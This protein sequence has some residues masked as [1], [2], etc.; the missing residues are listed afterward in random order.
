MSVIGC[1]FLV[2]VSALVATDAARAR[3]VT[4][5]YGNVVLELLRARSFDELDRHLA[6]LAK[7]KPRTPSGR[8]VLEVAY[9]DAANG[10]TAEDLESLR[11][12]AERRPTSPRALTLLGMALIDQAW[13]ARG[14]GTVETVSPE[15]WTLFHARIAAA[16][17]ALE[18]A[19]VLTKDDPNAAA[20]LITVCKAESAPHAEHQRWLARA[21]ELDPGD[22]TAANNFREA[23]S[24][25]WGGSDEAMLDFARQM[26]KAAPPGTQFPY[27]VMAAH[28]ELDGSLDDPDY[29]SRPEVKAEADEA[30]GRLLADFPESLAMRDL[31][32]YTALR[33]GDAAAAKPHLDYLDGR[34]VPGR[35]LSEGYYASMRRRVSEALMTPA[36]RRSGPRGLRKALRPGELLPT[37]VAVVDPGAEPREPLRFRFTPG[38]RSVLRLDLSGEQLQR[39]EQPRAPVRSLTRAL[40]PESI[41]LAAAVRTVDARGDAVLDLTIL[42]AGHGE[43]LVRPHVETPAEALATL[44]GATGHVT[45]TSRGELRESA[46]GAPAGSPPDVRWEWQRVSAPWPSWCLPFPEEPVGAGARWTATGSWWDEGDVMHQEVTCKVVERTE[47]TVTLALDG[48][49]DSG[50]KRIRIDGVPP[51]VP[52]ELAEHVVA[53]WTD[54]TFDL[55]RPLPESSRGGRSSYRHVCVGDAHAA[56]NTKLI[57]S[58]TL[59]LDWS[60]TDTPTEPTRPRWDASRPAPEVEERAPAA[61]ARPTVQRGS[62]RERSLAL[63]GGG[64][65]AALLLALLL[66]RRHR[67]RAAA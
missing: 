17:E 9:S 15:G 61:P 48:I 37:S 40:R 54:V 7:D 32:A 67:A 11:E 12:W 10:L 59:S 4:Q 19:A 1:R 51:D 60:G 66:V 35:W 62:G 52:V 28:L 8:R 45:M 46:F 24:A 3:P 22:V 64:G 21:L 26:A 65:V 33:R 34:Y 14:S 57:A 25:K 13:A 43:K 23:L 20:A 47:G 31:A 58:H 5:S 39:L 41:T 55:G 56:E 16:R 29:W 53:S 6:Q 30:L 27:L 50:R 18:K 2:L 49:A 44:P 38:A 42:D 63:A 36:E